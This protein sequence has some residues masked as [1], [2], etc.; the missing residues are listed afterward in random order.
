MARLSL[1][2]YLV[3]LLLFLVSLGGTG[4]A[5]IGAALAL[6]VGLTF[7]ALDWIGSALG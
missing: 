6:G 2:C 4:W 1:Q 7:T 3:A 5:M